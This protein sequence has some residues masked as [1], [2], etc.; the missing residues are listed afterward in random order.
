M[1]LVVWSGDKKAKQSHFNND[2]DGQSRT[3]S[4]PLS[5]CLLSGIM[6]CDLN[7]YLALRFTLCWSSVFLAGSFF[8]PAPL[9][10]HCP[11]QETNEKQRNSILI[12]LISVEWLSWSEKRVSLWHRCDEIARHSKKG[13]TG[14]CSKKDQTCKWLGTQDMKT[15]NRIFQGCLTL[16]VGHDTCI[17]SF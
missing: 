9:Q 10:S 16:S 7:F 4:Q 1:F 6:A 11:P 2:K 12:S 13:D 17:W 14:A 5:N 8:P 15:P 3:P